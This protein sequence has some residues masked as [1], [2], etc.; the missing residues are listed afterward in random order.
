MKKLSPLTQLGNSVTEASA[1]GSLPHLSDQVMVAAALDKALDGTALWVLLG[2]YR[3]FAVLDR[4]QAEEV[5]GICLTP[6]QF[7]ILTVLQRTGQPTTMGALSGMLVVKP[8]NLSGNINSL[9][10]RGLVK[11]ELNA[12][13]QRWLLAVLTPVG[14]EFLAEHLPDHWRRL[15]R[16]MYGLSREKRIQLVS[17]LRELLVS[18]EQEQERERA[19]DHS[20]K[21]S[22]AA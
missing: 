9:I 18:I 5:A 6:L 11:R 13:D 2:L 12:A 14:K 16:L 3:A 21:K 1:D 22:R 8:T 20:E 15:E 7:N 17:L 10:E 19:A 4:D